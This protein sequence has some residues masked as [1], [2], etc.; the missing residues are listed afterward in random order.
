MASNNNNNNKPTTTGDNKQCTTT[1]IAIADW[2][3]LWH[4]VGPF[5]RWQTTIILLVSA[6]SKCVSVNDQLY[7]DLKIFNRIFNFRIVIKFVQ[8]DSDLLVQRRQTD[9]IMAGYLLF[10]S[11][12]GTKIA[13]Q[14]A[15]V[16]RQQFGSNTNFTK[17][18]LRQLT[19]DDDDACHYVDI[20]YRR[21]AGM[22]FGQALNESR[23]IGIVRQCS[24]WTFN[25]SASAYKSSIQQDV[26]LSMPI[27]D[28][29]KNAKS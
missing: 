5:S 15:N 12:A 17:S 16:D 20:D 27:A 21:V 28:F 9:Y 22:P 25:A 23:R 8:S 29:V 10:Q 19:S 24:R 3:Q 26:I 13:H 1:T 11:F 14:C 18:Q 7:V 6:I 4:L 2:P